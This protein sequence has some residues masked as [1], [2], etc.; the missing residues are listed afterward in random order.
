MA[1][2]DVR[3]DEHSRLEAL[4][5]EGPQWIAHAH[6]VTAGWKPGEDF[7]V[8]VVARGLREAYEAGLQGEEYP[9]APKPTRRVR[10][11]KVEPQEEEEAP[12]VRVRRRR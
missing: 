7:L 4:R 3:D 8:S 1:R 2:R 5:K 12:V 9:P 11:A 10:P 6:A